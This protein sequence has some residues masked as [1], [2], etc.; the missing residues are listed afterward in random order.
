MKRTHAAG[1]LVAA[2]AIAGCRTAQPE[3]A[4]AKSEAFSATPVAAR[5]AISMGAWEFQTRGQIANWLSAE[6]SE[7]LPVG[8]DHVLVV[9]RFHLRWSELEA[10]TVHVVA[11]EDVQG[12]IAW[13]SRVP[14]VPYGIDPCAQVVEPLLCADVTAPERELV[15]REQGLLER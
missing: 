14:C 4:E 9:W 2:I 5:P 13:W 15:L 11:L 1:F 7:V 10:N 6:P 12:R 3:V 8:D